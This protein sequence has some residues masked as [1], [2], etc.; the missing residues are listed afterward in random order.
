M[1]THCTILVW[2]IPWTEEPGGLQS[3]GSQRVGHDRE[4]KQQLSLHWF[5]SGRVPCLIPSTWTSPKAHFPC[6]ASLSPHT[7]PWSQV[8]PSP[9][10]S[11][12]F[13]TLKSTA[14]AS[15]P[16]VVT[17]TRRSRGAFSSNE[18]THL[19]HRVLPPQNSLVL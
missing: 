2:R 15:A 1:A 4:T 17:F 11:G 12:D 8:K 7:S 3:M 9:G 5:L 16:L 18:S 10:L 6:P 13:R 19:P 14:L